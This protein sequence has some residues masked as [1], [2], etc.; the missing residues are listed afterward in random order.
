MIGSRRQVRQRER[1]VCAR[2]N[3]TGRTDAPVRSRD[4]R[5]GD[6][7]PRSILNRAENCPGRNLREQGWYQ[8]KRQKKGGNKKIKFR[9]DQL[10]GLSV[11]WRSSDTGSGINT[12]V[13]M[14]TAQRDASN[15]LAKA[16]LKVCPS[17]N[18]DPDVE[19]RFA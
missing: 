2:G 17:M 12:A 8:P 11:R 1:A 13:R 19:V 7:R 15:R 9:F 6:Y 14:N 4:L 16:S 5:A 3:G 10:T 18:D